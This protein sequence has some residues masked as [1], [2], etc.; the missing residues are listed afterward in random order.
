MF[1]YTQKTID[2]KLKNQ[3]AIINFRLGMMRD[4]LKEFVYLNAYMSEAYERTN[5]TMDKTHLKVSDF[6]N[7][8]Q[9]F[10]VLQ[11]EHYRQNAKIVSSLVYFEDA[12][13][14]KRLFWEY[15]KIS[16]PY[17]RDLRKFVQIRFCISNPGECNSKEA[18][19]GHLAEL[20][21]KIDDYQIRLNGAYIDVIAKIMEDIRR[22]E[23]ES[24]KFK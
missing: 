8:E 22:A 5:F 13:I 18:N 23:D 12:N 17:L 6:K 2:W 10:L 20:N 24:E 9:Q 3:F 21:K 15:V 1:Q 16:T 19:E 4:C 11:N 7:Y 14:L